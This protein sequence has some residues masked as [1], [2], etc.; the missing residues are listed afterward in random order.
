MNDRTQGGFAYYLIFTAALAMAA[1]QFYTAY[2]GSYTPMVQRG[3]HLAFGLGLIFLVYPARKK[4]RSGAFPVFDFILALFTAV[5][6]IYAMV[7]FVEPTPI[8]LFSPTTADKIFGIAAIV[9]VLEGARRTTG[10]ALPIV[11]LVFLVYAF[12]G[13]YIPGSFGH[14]GV[15]LRHLISVNYMQLDGI[16]GTPTGASAKTIFVL[17]IFGVTMLQLGGGDFL[18]KLS[19]ALLGSTRGGP[20]KIAVVASALFATITGVGPANAAA[21]GVFTIP[22]M[23]R[24]GYRSHFA[25][26]VEAVASSGGQIMPPVMGIAAFLMAEIL[27]ISY[28]DVCIAALLPAMLYFIAV[29]LMVHFEAVRHDIKGLP[30]ES[31]ENLWVILKS[32]WH[33]I[34]PLLVLIV[35]IGVYESSPQKAGFWAMLLLIGFY[36]IKQVARRERPAIMVVLKAIEKGVTS[37]LVVCAISAAV[38]IIISI[39][40]LTGIGLKLSTILVELAHGN[41]VVLLIITMVASLILGMGMTTVACYII[42]SILAAPALVQMGILPI[43]AHLFVFYFGIMSAITPPVAMSSFVAAGIAGSPPMKTAWASF[44]LG[45]A[46]FIL[47]YMFVYNPNLLLR[48]SVLNVSLAVLSALIGT[49]ALSIAIQGSFLSRRSLGPLRRTLIFLGALSLIHSGMVSDLIGLL[50]ILGSISRDLLELRAR[51]PNTEPQAVT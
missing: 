40:N 35:F 21:T 45:L 36:C 11:T 7:N 17:I 47:P 33:Y 38:G 24:V 31:D 12:W 18:L 14:A 6:F 43:A 42:V 51:K 19:S 22:L 28:L 23:K 50:L 39:I 15:K 8:R 34:V 3:V 49:M 26:A 27:N 37:S 1:F 13:Q 4:G 9:L 32:G 16:F 10:N 30:R 29:F 48:G 46:A 5:V 20:A 41:L 2:V 44:K 25:A